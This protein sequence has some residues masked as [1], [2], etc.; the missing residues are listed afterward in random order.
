MQ[1]GRIALAAALAALSCM[2]DALS[3]EIVK[4]VLIDA[5]RNIRIAAWSASSG[6]LDPGSPV[7]WRVE[8][9]VLHGGRQEG[10]DRIR[11]QS[12]SLSFTVVPTRGMNLWE[13][14]SGDVRL[15][16][17][18]PVKEVVHPHHVNLTE[19]GGLGWLE[20]FAEWVNRCGLA[21]C[22][23]PGQ[24]RVRSNTGTIVPVDLTLHGKVSYIPA[25]SVEVVVE[26]GERRT[27]K[28]RGVVDETMMFGTQL[29]LV[30]E[31]S[32]V[33]G[34]T[35]IT[36][37]DEIRN[38]SPSE[39]EF[40][41]LYHANFGKPLLGGGARLVA[42]ALRVTPRDARA[43]EGDIGRW[44]HYDPPTAGFIEQVYYLKLAAGPDGRTEVLLKSPDGGRGVSVLFNARELPCMTLWKNT[45][46]EG[47]GYVTGIEPAT[48]YANNRS[49]ER[50]NGRVPVLAGGA[51]FKTALTFTVHHD[52]P[53]VAEAEARVKKLLGDA[54]A[55]LDPTTM[56]DVSP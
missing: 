32:T 36:V 27:I 4:Q 21:S 25:R 14:R 8:K 55:Q 44:S 46:A 45:V 37:S 56:P 53:A 31:I 26:G 10:V 13:A 43:A 42:P 34:S 29:Q 17:D 48:S 6:D 23:A 7:P 2:E 5:D 41:I 22:G 54:R 28:V 1:A 18:S 35:S 19:R 20:G 11:V 40:Q 30:T 3:A 16:W 51:S 24:D 38:L 39:Q 52:A 15:G 33:A 49:F 50:K 12:G 47:S 9:D